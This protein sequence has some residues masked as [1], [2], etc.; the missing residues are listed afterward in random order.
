MKRLPVIALMA[1]ASI[2]TA[3]SLK[4][5]GHEI[6]AN[7]PFN[8]AVGSRQLPAGQYKFFSEPNDMIVI[9]N[10]N[11]QVT[12]LSKTENAVNALG[13]SSRLVFNKYGDH[14]F[15]REI[16]CPSIAVN[17]EIP[18]SKQ[19]KQIRQQQAWLGP[20]QVLLALN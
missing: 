13:E 16:H 18:P 6:R 10:G 1:L 5:Q 9:R 7:V 19:E 8:F 4:A 12:I 20:D 15:L 11:Q 2:C 14:Y 17:V 3:G